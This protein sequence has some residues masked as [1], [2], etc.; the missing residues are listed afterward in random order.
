MVEVERKGQLADYWADARKFL[1]TAWRALV[2]ERRPLAALALLALLPYLLYL[3][4]LQRRK[5]L[6]PPKYSPFVYTMQ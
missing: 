6:N 4:E 5:L 1:G 3:R 2:S